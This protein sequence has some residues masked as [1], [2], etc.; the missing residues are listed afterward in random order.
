MKDAM[1]AAGIKIS[2]L[3]KR[4]GVSRT[5][6]Y[7]YINA[8]ETASES[9]PNN[10]R[11]FFDRLTTQSNLNAEKGKILISECFPTKSESINKET[12]K[13][14]ENIIE[15]FCKEEQDQ[16]N[17]MPIVLPTGARKTSSVV[18]YIAKYVKNGGEQNILFVTTLKKNLPVSEISEEDRL[19]KSFEENGIG[20]LYDEKVLVIDSLPHM[21]QDNYPK[22]SKLEKSYL[23]AKMGDSTADQLDTFLRS[24]KE[25]SISKMTYDDVFDKFS[26]FEKKFRFRI[27]KLLKRDETDDTDR[28]DL[29]TKD[30]GWKWVSKIYPTVYTSDR[31]IFLM[32]MDKFMTFHDT[33]IE[34]RYSIYDSKM[35]DNAIIFID[36]FDATK[37][38]VLKSIIRN[39]KG[40]LDYAGI[41]KRIHRTL[42]HNGDI[43]KEYYRMAEYSDSGLTTFEK[44]TEFYEEVKSLVAEY[45]LELDF[46]MDDAVPESFLF[47]DSR[48]VKT[49]NNNQYYIEPDY[50]ERINRIICV[51]KGNDAEDADEYTIEP[52]RKKIST[53]LGKMYSLFAFFG[54]IMYTM[55]MHH[56]RIQENAGKS[57]TRDEAIRTVLDPYDFNESQEE[58]LVNFIK[59]KPPMNKKQKDSTPDLSFYSKGFEYFNFVDDNSHNLATKIYCKSIKRTPEKM[60]LMPLNPTHNAKIV[61]ISATARFPSVIGNYDLRY[62]RSQES[63]NEYILT[64]NERERLR[65]MFQ[66]TIDCYDRV[67]INTTLIA[68]DTSIFDIIKD[69][70]NA[71]ELDQFLESF[72]RDGSFVKNRYLRVFSVYYK[73]LRATDLR[74]FLCFMN[75]FPKS[76]NARG[77]KEF[78][79]EILSIAFSIMISE[80][81]EELKAQGKIIPD[82]ILKLKEQP[83][84]IMK[85]NDYDKEKKTL[86]ERLSKG[87]KIFVFT[88]YS[89]VGAGQNLQYDIPS[90]VKDHIRYISS[91]ANPEETNRMDFNG[92]YLDM[93]TNII[94]NVDPY[95]DESLLTALF[96][97]ESMQENNEMNY[98]TAKNEIEVAFKKYFNIPGAFSERKGM[99]YPSYRMAYARTIIQAVGRI[100]RTYAKNLNI[101]IMADNALGKVFKGTSL[102][103]YTDPDDKGCAEDNIMVNPEFRALFE[104]L[105]NSTVSIRGS[106]DGADISNECIKTYAYIQSKI[107]KRLWSTNSIRSWKIVREY[108]LRFPTIDAKTKLDFVYNMYT[109]LPAAT[110]SIR[111]SQENDYKIV[112]INNSGDNEVSQSDARLDDFLKIPCVRPLF[113][114]PTTV[115]FESMPSE[116]D[117]ENIPYA[118]SFAKNTAIMCPTLYHNI[119][120]GALGEIAGTA[121]LED[122]GIEVKEITDPDKFEK[123]DAVTKSGVYLDFKHWYGPNGKDDQTFV[124]W[125]FQKLK[126]IGGKKAIIINILKPIKDEVKSEGY[127]LC[128]KD[129]SKDGED[130]NDLTL[131]TVPYLY[132]CNGN[133]AILN[134]EA[135]K[136]IENAVRE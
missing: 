128:G 8:Y 129:F 4:V 19:R 65:S 116:A 41:F 84:V 90:E 1:D 54:G 52:N 25:A 108:V 79:Q 70:D 2:E 7:K 51:K 30:N 97:I 63:F 136:T 12:D 86:L 29:V 99:E 67:N 74:S 43:W 132:D 91:L 31:Q 37:A 95:D 125:A 133:I 110:N 22:L 20:S 115:D 11:A 120:K 68:D 69:V 64:P 109:K 112:H 59:F 107:Q 131:I 55:A 94:S 27:A 34:G 10:V 60:L 119:Y 77:E 82:Y 105:Q 72:G 98:Y 87:E 33:I 14:L 102:R 45:S 5:M 28:K 9:I 80:Y 76:E 15:N 44:I 85:S 121:I 124:K 36:E 56:Y 66:K 6:M 35:I 13:A 40:S 89:T 93:P 49:G 73:F 103:D 111:Y 118:E 96:S 58:Y 17:F 100:C 48:L 53:M 47:R 126:M 122:W 23:R 78:S 3:S 26:E 104:E 114:P 50:T 46:K 123:F 39:D 101:Y 75:L 38:T 81:C 135:K 16:Y 130:F 24:L 57:I 61:G 106:G 134:P 18:N 42:E 92:I 88:T 117:L 21:L 32:S 83:F 127:E 62:L 71:D 113:G